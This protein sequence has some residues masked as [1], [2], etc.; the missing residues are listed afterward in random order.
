MRIFIPISEKI[1]SINSDGRVLP[2]GLYLKFIA[3]TNAKGIFK[4]YWQVVNTGEAAKRNN[5]LR[6][7]IFE[8]NQVRGEHTKYQGKHW[9][10]CFIVQ[11]NIC[12]A[13]SGKFFVNIR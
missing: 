4:Y 10:E 5:D 2:P 7:N 11:N 1:R 8:G 12:V 13:R 9:I 6:G 3:R